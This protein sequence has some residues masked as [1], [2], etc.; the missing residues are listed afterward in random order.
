LTGPGAPTRWRLAG[1]SYTG[2]GPRDS[3]PAVRN[4]RLGVNRNRVADAVQYI[5]WGPWEIVD[6]SV[7][8]DPFGVLR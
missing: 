2:A 6:G 7:H 3:F 1:R 8:A 4:L 5:Y